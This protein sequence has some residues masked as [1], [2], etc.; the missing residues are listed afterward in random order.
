MGISIDPPGPAQLGVPGASLVAQV[1]ATGPLANTTIANIAALPAGLYKIDVY[2]ELSG[3]V[4]AADQDNIRLQVDGVT[5]SR[6]NMSAAITSGDVNSPV[7]IYARSNGTS[8]RVQSVGA[9]TGTAIY[10]TMI[11]ATQVSA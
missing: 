11:V 7:T 10:G 8:I 3:T 6:L 2:L 5:V 4:A 1:S 9:A